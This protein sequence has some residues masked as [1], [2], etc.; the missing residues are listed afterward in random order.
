MQGKSWRDGRMAVA[1][2]IG[3]SRHTARRSSC[4]VLAAAVSVVLTQAAANTATATEPAAYSARIDIPAQSLADSIQA[5]ARQTN[6]NILVDPSLVA[7]RTAPAIKEELSIEAALKKLLEGTKL[8]PKF[9]DEKTIVVAAVPDSARVE[10]ARAFRLAQSTS[11]TSTGSP[12]SSASDVA[13]RGDGGTAGE[14]APSAERAPGAPSEASD[15]TIDEIVVTAQKREERLQDV[16]ISI[17]VLTSEETERP[18]FQDVKDMLRTVPGVFSLESSSTG[19]NQFTV[20]GVT[21]NTSLFGGSAVIGYYLDE[22]PFAFVR[23]P[24]TPDA[25]AYD[26]E[27]L[28]V[29]RGPQ[30]TLYGVNSLNGVVRS[31]TTDANLDEF[32]AKAR[33]SASSTR[34][35]GENYGADAAVSVPIVPGKLAA[36]V[37]AGFE[38]AS[39]WIDVP[40]AQKK[41][42]NDR[43]DRN[44]RIKLNAEPME[45]LRLELLG[46][47]SRVKHGG[48]SESNADRTVVAP[49][50]DFNADFDAYSLVAEY[51][52]PRFTV[53]SATSHIEYESSAEPLIGGAVPFIVVL[54]TSATSQEFRLTSHNNSAWRWTLGTIY[55][56]ADDSRLQAA[57][58]VF[59][60]A[61]VQTYASKSVAAYGELTRSLLDDKVDITAGLRGF[62]DE[63]STTEVRTLQD[64]PAYG[65]KT[66]TFDAWTPRAVLTF[67]PV[68]DTTVYASYGQGFR[69]GFQQDGVTLNATQGAAK[70]VNPDRL[71]NIELG[72]KGSVFDRILSY[73]LALYHINWKDAVQFY[74][75]EIARPGGTA[76]R[77]GAAVNSE[78]IRGKGVDALLALNLS[79]RF[80]VLG[81]LSWNDL[82]FSDDVVGAT[83]V[84]FREGMRPQNS[85][86]WTA[87]GEINYWAPLG[88]EFAAR[89]NGGVN[90]HSKISAPDATLALVSGDDIF[91]ARASL[92]L[93]TPRFDVT[94]FGENLTNEYGRIR[95]SIDPAGAS[96]RLR[97]RTIGVQCMTRF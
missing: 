39:G 27:R 13:G 17:S 8:T 65:T 2:P 14:D 36:R 69:S 32:E 24:L 97:P 80:S 48:S 64:T 76:L 23:T 71:T 41:D 6:T 72:I 58:S 18:Y 85:P 46:W 87:G 31:I 5:V 74:P 25:K 78:A 53:F 20:R 38:D 19:M 81:T 77:T 16:P 9:V 47:F 43:A 75:V 55:R 28:E 11:A 93:E 57:P 34:Y 44:A 7:G 79:R 35:G 82:Q 83:G 52:L 37:V 42:H 91:T 66:D 3:K 40:A 90:Y 73:E 15:Q 89:F 26:M 94:L 95:Q 12:L 22:I 49:L 50:Y 67:R 10:D 84:I 51:D 61:V 68:A 63:V 92:T 96:E 33:A 1:W 86:E 54:G 60:G 4:R 56:D 21:S 29:L 30:G 88:R 59:P 45:G 70:D 62:R